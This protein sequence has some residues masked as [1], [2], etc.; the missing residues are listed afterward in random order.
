MALKLNLDGSVEDNHLTSVHPVT[1]T[2]QDVGQ[3]IPLPRGVAHVGVVVKDGNDDPL[4][5]GSDWVYGHKCLH[6]LNLF[7]IEAYGSIILINTAT[8]TNISI[9]AKYLGNNYE[10]YDAT[11][12][13]ATVEKREGEWPVLYWDTGYTA[14]FIGVDDYETYPAGSIGLGL[15]AVSEMLEIWPNMVAGG[16]DA[17]M[18]ADTIATPLAGLQDAAPAET[19][20]VTVVDAINDVV[21]LFDLQFRSSGSINGLAHG[22]S[23]VADTDLTKLTLEENT[24]FDVV[25]NGV[26]VTYLSEDTGEVTTETLNRGVVLVVRAVGLVTTK[27]TD[28]RD[29]LR[30]LP[31]VL[32]GLLTDAKDLTGALNE[33]VTRITGGYGGKYQNYGTL[34]EDTD[35]SDASVIDPGFYLVDGDISITAKFGEAVA[36]KQFTS[37][38]VLVMEGDT[39]TKLAISA[40]ADTVYPIVNQNLPGPD[41]TP[42]GVITRANK[43]LDTVRVKPAYAVDVAV[44]PKQ[45]ARYHHASEIALTDFALDANLAAALAAGGYIQFPPTWKQPA[46]ITSALYH[47]DENDGVF[48]QIAS[49]GTTTMVLRELSGGT[50]KVSKYNLEAKAYVDSLAAFPNLNGNVTCW[51]V[52]NGVLYYGS[53][54]TLYSSDLTGTTVNEVYTHSGGAKAFYVDAVLDYLYVHTSTDT[55]V[56]V[57]LSN[58]NVQTIILGAFTGS[59]VGGPD[60]VTVAVNDD[61]VYLLVEE[62]A[63]QVAQYQ[64]GHVYGPMYYSERLKGIVVLG[65]DSRLLYPLSG[66]AVDIGLDIDGTSPFFYKDNAYCISGGDVHKLTSQHRITRFIRG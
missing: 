66:A 8:P 13:D 5:L 35:F 12:L 43:T 14:P 16:V 58:G 42:L 51:A 57:D 17:Q 29:A 32:P 3:L 25:K 15:N 61:A 55:L 22:N 52:D 38:Y 50:F 46:M 40:L 64:P 39:A 36:T 20:G 23:I 63:S 49:D 18:V 7:G 34:S 47:H 9:E 33:L 65:N 1:P 53:G 31:R 37:D 54:D 30:Q 48:H 41:K 27:I 21:S 24:Y 26:A 60:G 62:Q 2:G 19:P 10:Q 28:Y 11:K 59:L 44:A 45:D 4:T 56:G 6:A